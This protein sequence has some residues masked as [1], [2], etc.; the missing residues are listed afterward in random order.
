MCHSF[1]LG[2]LCPGVEIPLRG[3]S[4]AAGA[5]DGESRAWALDHVLEGM[6]CGDYFTVSIA[7]G[8]AGASALDLW[9]LNDS[10]L[11]QGY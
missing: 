7:G 10:P 3:F 6:G 8:L 11:K 9:A 5:L 2:R 1:S 4:E